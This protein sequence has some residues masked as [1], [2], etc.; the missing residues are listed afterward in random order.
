MIEYLYDAIRAH[1]GNDLVITA[2]ITDNSKE[3]VTEGCSLMFH[4]TDKETMI[5][6]IKGVY[7]ENDGWTF[8]IPAEL[9]KERTGR[10]WYCI[11]HEGSALCFKQPIYLV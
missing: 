8:T 10:Y 6:E 5:A 2:D 3:T 1:A 11:T 9:T 4:D 7:D